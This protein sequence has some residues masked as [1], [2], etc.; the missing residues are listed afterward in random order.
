MSH[1]DLQI[2]ANPYSPISIKQKKVPFT[3]TEGGLKQEKTK[4]NMVK[5]RK[6]RKDQL[7]P[8]LAPQRS[9]PSKPLASK[10]LTEASTSASLSLKFRYL[11]R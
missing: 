4:E 2:V 7:E 8:W 1:I 3:D 5:K 9:S 6:P 10:A 11:S